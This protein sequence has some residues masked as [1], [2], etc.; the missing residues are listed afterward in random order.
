V[1]LSLEAL[2]KLDA[3]MNYTSI[4]YSHMWITNLCGLCFF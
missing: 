1:H 4:C 2:N 3:S